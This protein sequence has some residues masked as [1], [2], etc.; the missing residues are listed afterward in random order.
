MRAGAD[1]FSGST[2]GAF[3]AVSLERFL[4]RLPDTLTVVHDGRVMRGPRGV[5]RGSAAEE[6]NVVACSRGNPRGPP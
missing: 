5:V 1:Q 6:K 4:N 2:A 3:A